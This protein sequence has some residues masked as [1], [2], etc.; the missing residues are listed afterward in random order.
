MLAWT[1]LSEQDGHIICSQIS[2]RLSQDPSLW[3]SKVCSCVMM[4]TVNVSAS[5]GWVLYCTYVF[6]LEMQVKLCTQHLHLH[7]RQR[8]CSSVIVLL[9]SCSLLCVLQIVAKLFN[10][11]EPDVAVFGKKDYQQWRVIC[12]MARDLDFDIEI[13]G[14]ATGREADGMAMSSRNALLTSE[15]RQKAVCIS[16]ALKVGCHLHNKACVNFMVTLNCTQATS[17]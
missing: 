14:I 4:R 1:I 13:V 12:R 6:V 3:R 8:S 10:I 15:N 11:V 5:S 7:Q 9:L 2:N 17:A 16:Q